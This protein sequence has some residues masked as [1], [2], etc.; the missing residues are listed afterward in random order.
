MELEAAELRGPHKLW[1]CGLLAPPLRLILA[2]VFFIYSTKNPRKFPGHSENFYFCAKTTPW[3]F[4]SKQRQSGLVPLKS[5]KL[6]SKTRA[7][8][9]GKVDTME[10]YQ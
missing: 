8:E 3:Q 9:F 2:P 1:A 10:T 6:E 7:K 5:C 4:C